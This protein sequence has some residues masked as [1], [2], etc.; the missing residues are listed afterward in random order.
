MCEG[1]NLIA[2]WRHPDIP[3]LNGMIIG[4]SCDDIGGDRGRGTRTDVV[5]VGGRKGEKGRFRGNVPVGEKGVVSSGEK[6]E[7]ISSTRETDDM[8]RAGM[9]AEAAEGV[10]GAEGVEDLDKA[11]LASSG[12]EGAVAAKGG[13][14][15][16]VLEGGEG[17][18]GLRG[19]RSAIEEMYGG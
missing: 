14:I 7:L 13:R 6:V 11:G 18:V 3:D 19:E 5:T 8:N 17:G 2:I 9:C 12:E 4:S 16:D 1:R 15:G 10:A